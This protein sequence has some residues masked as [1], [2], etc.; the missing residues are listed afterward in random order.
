MSL[1][2]L[3]AKLAERVS[4]ENRETGKVLLGKEEEGGDEDTDKP[5][6]VSPQ[7]DGSSRPGEDG[8]LSCKYSKLESSKGEKLR[9]S[10]RTG[11]ESRLA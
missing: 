7:P 1:E 8:A 10:G 5:L 2:R 11:T 3:Q 4:G 6:V 9:L